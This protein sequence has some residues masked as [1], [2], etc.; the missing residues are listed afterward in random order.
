MSKTYQLDLIVIEK[1]K[2]RIEFLEKE[3]QLLRRKLDEA[4]ISYVEILPESNNIGV[5]TEPYDKNQ[6]ARIKS[7][8]VTDMISSDFFM[9]FC[10]GRKDGYSLRYSN[11]RTGKTGYYR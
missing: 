9:M 10:R 7:F 11:P 5:E 3:N 2:T 4:G 1:L 8:E 6:G